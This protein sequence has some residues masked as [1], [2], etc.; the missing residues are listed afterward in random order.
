MP[1]DPAVYANMLG[2]KIAKY[3]TSVYLVNT[4]WAGGSA[5]EL[6]EGRPDEAALHPGHGHRR[7][8]RRAGKRRV[9]ALRDL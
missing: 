6:G 3:G 5:Q 1:M 9:R 2:E 8:E 7:P 4:G